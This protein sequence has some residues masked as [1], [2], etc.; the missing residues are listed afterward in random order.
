MEA[1]FVST[2][3]VALGEIGDK[4]QLLALMLAVRFRRPWPIVA[5][6]LVARDNPVT[7]GGRVLQIA[8]QPGRRAEQQHARQ[9]AA[10]RGDPG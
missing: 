9:P 1:F 10:D 4:T 5:G 3:V 6:I 8:A 2:A 7:L